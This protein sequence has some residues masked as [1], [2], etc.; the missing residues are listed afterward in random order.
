M[1]KE[2]MQKEEERSR[3]ETWPGKYKYIK[4]YHSYTDN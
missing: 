4:R 1:P 2:Q 3:Q